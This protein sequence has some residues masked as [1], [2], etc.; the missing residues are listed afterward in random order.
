MRVSNQE[1]NAISL[2][3][4][5]AASTVPPNG[6]DAS[7]EALRARKKRKHASPPQSK[8]VPFPPPQMFRPLELIRLTLIALLA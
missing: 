2:K 4:L 5:K 7:S 1:D 3:I 8:K 6:I